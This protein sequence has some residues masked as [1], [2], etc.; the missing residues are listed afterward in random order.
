MIIVYGADWCEDTRQ[1]L[2]HLR[3][4]GVAHQYVNIDEDVDALHRATAL[5][6]GQRRT[7][8]IDL[9]LG[10]APLVEPDNDT[11]T[12]ALIEV[13]ML[14]QDVAYER[15]A[16]QNVGDLDRVLRTATGAGL[17]LAGSL[18]PRA[19]RWPLR[20]AGTAVAL[21]GVA[22]W[23]PAYHLAG[24]SS[25]EGPGDRPGE[26]HRSVWLTRRPRSNSNAASVHAGADAD[27]TSVRR[28][29]ADAKLTLVRRSDDG[30]EAAR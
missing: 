16:V 24:V 4:L 8:T 5:N 9:G 27:A 13:E 14:S 30:A 26:A 7:P 18:A 23:C 6:G 3:R 28:S 20:I 1:S 29:R 12:G 2:R 21:S 10:G 19:A 17:I 15:L 25:I 22:G 11:L